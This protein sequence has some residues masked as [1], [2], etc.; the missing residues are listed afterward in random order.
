MSTWIIFRVG[1]SEIGTAPLY[2]V[3]SIIVEM[4]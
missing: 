2:P 4:P 1:E 3:A